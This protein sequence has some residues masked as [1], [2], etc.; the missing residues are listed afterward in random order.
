MKDE[1]AK[2]NGYSVFFIHSSTLLPS[3]SSR[4]DEIDTRRFYELAHSLP[5]D[6]PP[7]A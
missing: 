4:A 5:I 3:K 2:N 6:N 7:F 1:D